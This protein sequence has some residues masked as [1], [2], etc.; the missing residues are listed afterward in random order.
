MALG[1]FLGGAG[2]GRGGAGACGIPVPARGRCQDDFLN[3]SSLGG[4]PLPCAHSSSPPA[5]RPL[6][7]P[8]A[9]LLGVQ[10][11]GAI[12][13]RPC[14]PKIFIGTGV[15]ASG[16]GAGTPEPPVFQVPLRGGQ[17]GAHLKVRSEVLAQGAYEMG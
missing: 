15:G 9:W 3:P 13:V 11:T 16:A 8:E 17:G 10:S 2:G 7:A 5:T 6:S 4:S 12:G 14:Q 1:L